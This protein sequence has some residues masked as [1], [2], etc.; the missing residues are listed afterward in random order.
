MTLSLLDR[1]R[2]VLVP[3]NALSMNYVAIITRFVILS[4]LTGR[5]TQALQAN[6]QRRAPEGRGAGIS[7]SSRSATSDTP[8]IQ[9]PNYQQ[10]SSSSIIDGRAIA[11]G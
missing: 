7:E 9:T 11:T 10:A 8:R 4:T 5:P 3:V 1:R 6:F 2:A